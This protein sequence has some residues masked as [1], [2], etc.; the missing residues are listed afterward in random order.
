MESDRRRKIDLYSRK[1][2][3]E[4]VFPRKKWCNTIYT[5]SLCENDSEYSS[6]NVFI[7]TIHPTVKG[8]WRTKAQPRWTQFWE[9]WPNKLWFRGLIIYCQNSLELGFHQRRN[10]RL[11]MLLGIVLCQYSWIGFAI[12]SKYVE[13][14]VSLK[15]PI[16]SHCTI[17][18][19]CS[20]CKRRLNEKVGK[21]IQH[22][23]C[24]GK[25]LRGRIG[26][27]L[28]SPSTFAYRKWVFCEQFSISHQTNGNLNT[29][30]KSV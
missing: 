3:I 13:I 24:D 23:L 9:R 8:I 11:I 19:Y 28:G 18:T 27:T 7:K 10:K 30:S 20:S 22:L 29:V 4:I 16:T 5:I 6:A 17:G 2:S 21:S 14:S 15:F 1:K 12:L 26:W 25:S